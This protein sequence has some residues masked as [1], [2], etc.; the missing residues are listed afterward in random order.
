[1]G[2]ESRY[3]LFKSFNTNNVFYYGNRANPNGG[4]D[5]YESGVIRPDLL[6]TDLIW[7][8]H[9][10]LLNSNYVPVYIQRAK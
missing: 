6:L 10:H 8:F 3:A 9:R 7:I 2:I 4:L 1:L 5:Y